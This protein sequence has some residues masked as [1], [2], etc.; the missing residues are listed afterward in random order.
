MSK[1]NKQAFFCETQCSDE[2]DDQDYIDKLI[3]QKGPDAMNAL[4]K[5]QDYFENEN[6]R[7]EIAEL[8]DSLL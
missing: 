4:M 8:R 2:D 6:E 3:R 7:D 1:K 5:D